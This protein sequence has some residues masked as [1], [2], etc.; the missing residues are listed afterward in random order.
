[1]AQR[2]IEILVGRLITNESFRAAFLGD[3]ITTLIGFMDAGYELTS[4]EIAALRA[5]PVELWE[6]AAER[7]DLRLQQASLTPGQEEL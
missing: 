5:T 4:V 2:S 1:V 3:A 7:I 6:K